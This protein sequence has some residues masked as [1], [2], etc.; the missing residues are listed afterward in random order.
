MTPL[1]LFIGRE[2]LFYTINRRTLNG[3][4]LCLV[5]ALLIT[6]GGVWGSRHSVATNGNGGLSFQKE[7]QTPTGNATPDFLKNYGACF[8]GDTTQKV[9]YLTFDAG[10]ENGCTTQ[11]LDVL[12]KHNVPAAFFLVGNYMQTNPDLVKRMADEGHIVGNHCVNHYDMT[13][14]SVE[15]FV[16]EVQGLEDYFYTSFPDAKPMLYFRPPSGNCNE[17]VLKFA[18]LMGYTTVMWSWAYF[19][20]DV[21][22]Q[23]S[24]SD[25]LQKVKD[26]LHNGCVYLLHTESQTNADML[27]DM[28][29]WVRSQGYEFLPLA[30]IK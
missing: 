16:K 29:D 8:V 28:I 18:D 24:V 5:L 15:T 23:P 26:G 17:W 30:D 27:G 1:G 10:Y 14:V 22:N 2:N 12:K 20:Y 11:I 19:D 7:G 9:I 13:A 25:A 3:I 4:A 6:V 21:N